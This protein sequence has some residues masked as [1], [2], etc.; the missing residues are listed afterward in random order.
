MET[1]QNCEDV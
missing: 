1:S